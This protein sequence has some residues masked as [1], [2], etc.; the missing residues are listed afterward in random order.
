V[1]TQGK[2]EKVMELGS[3]IGYLAAILATIAAVPQ[4]YKTWKTKSADDLSYLTLIFLLV[5]KPNFGFI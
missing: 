4:A 3:V 1:A 2:E 5:Q